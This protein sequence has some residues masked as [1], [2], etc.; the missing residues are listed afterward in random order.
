M[1][2]GLQGYPVTRGMGATCVPI[3]FQGIFAELHD[4]ESG[5]LLLLFPVQNE[6]RGEEQGSLDWEGRGTLYELLRRAASLV[7][8]AILEM[9]ML[10]SRGLSSSR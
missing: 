3:E 10:F 7:G 6:E 1:S 5:K 9:I 2:D 4:S 8:A